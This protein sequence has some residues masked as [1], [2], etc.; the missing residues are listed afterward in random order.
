MRRHE[1]A[2]VPLLLLVGSLLALG[3]TAGCRPQTSSTPS[4]SQSGETEAETA[5]ETTAVPSPR[6]LTAPATFFGHPEF[7]V[8]VSAWGWLPDSEKLVAAYADG[9]VRV[10]DPDTET[11]T[12]RLSVHS[13]QRIVDLCISAHGVVTRDT[14]GRV[15]RTSFDGT[16]I[17]GKLEGPWCGPEADEECRLRDLQC[18]PESDLLALRSDDRLTIVESIDEPESPRVLESIVDVTVSPDGE[19][20]VMQR[21]QSSE[22]KFSVLRDPFAAS[23]AEIPL[24]CDVRGNFGP[25]AVF[26]PTSDTVA[27][28]FGDASLPYEICAWSLSGPSPTDVSLKVVKRK[29]SP[30][31]SDDDVSAINMSGRFDSPTR[32]T[33]DVAFGW[34]GEGFYDVYDD[35]ITWDTRSGAIVRRSLEPKKAKPTTRVATEGPVIHVDRPGSSRKSLPPWTEEDRNLTAAITTIDVA[36]DGSRLHLLRRGSILMTHDTSTGAAL[37]AHTV[38]WPSVGPVMSIAVSDDSQRLLVGYD[39]TFPEENEECGEL[40]DGGPGGLLRV[41]L[42]DGTRTELAEHDRRRF[43]PLS[44]LPGTHTALVCNEDYSSPDYFFECGEPSGPG[45]DGTLERLDLDTGE[46]VRLPVKVD[47]CP[48]RNA[49][50]LAAERVAV[51]RAPADRKPGLWGD[52]AYDEEPFFDVEVAS[53]STGASV[54]RTE[55]S[56]PVLHYALSDDGSRLALAIPDAVELIG[57]DGVGIERRFALPSSATPTSMALS[58]DGAMLVVG[59]EDGTVRYWSEGNNGLAAPPQVNRDEIFE[60]RFDST[61]SLFTVSDDDTAFRWP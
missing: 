2:S 34:I 33:A 4:S 21:G 23:S 11:A 42:D 48:S 25:S 51:L 45:P 24:P 22:A 36:S 15:R 9:T 58:P 17:T 26:S 60:L 52:A 44:F 27:L 20:L 16:A 35:F 31:E 18:S 14:E 5:T 38:S 40:D 29:R 46:A 13:P 61:G 43:V 47:A 7:A 50:G 6:A 49:I 3:T 8:A 10:W 1:S 56:R 39:A 55:K 30:V 41:D 12:P 32:F 19:K 54:F 57:L 37:E 28:Y 53:W 59:F